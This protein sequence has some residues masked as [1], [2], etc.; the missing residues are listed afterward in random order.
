[1][2]I[3]VVFSWFLAHFVYNCIQ[4]WCFFI[5]LSKILWQGVTFIS[6]LQI[7]ILWSQIVKFSRLRRAISHCKSWFCGP[8]LSKFP[9]LRRAFVPWNFHPE[10]W[11]QKLLAQIQFKQRNLG[12][13]EKFTCYELFFL[14]K[15]IN[16]WT[17]RCFEQGFLWTGRCLNLAGP[18]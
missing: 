14:K 4:N 2:K 6:P 15:I 18:F 1:M 9:R 13:I 11:R 16:T 7:M 10:V 12:E 3:V 5:I 8:E 17:G